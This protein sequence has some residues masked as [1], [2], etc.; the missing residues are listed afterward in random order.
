MSPTVVDGIPH[1]STRCPLAKSVSTNSR[2]HFL[3]F[4]RH[5]AA[6]TAVR[7]ELISLSVWPPARKPYMAAGSTKHAIK[8]AFVCSGNG[9]HRMRLETAMSFLTLSS[10]TSWSRILSDLS[11]LTTSRCSPFNS[12]S[13]ADCSDVSEVPHASFFRHS[14]PLLCNYGERP[15]IFNAMSMSALTLLRT[16]ASSV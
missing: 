14:Q 6:T 2:H 13:L 8:L 1:G 9:A 11:F 3:R 5:R 12:K 4:V 10:A 15:V 7:S 16:P